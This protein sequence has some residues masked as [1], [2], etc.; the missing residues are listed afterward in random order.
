MVHPR[1]MELSWTAHP[2]KRRPR[3]LALVCAV[4][5]LTAG[6]VL[7]SFESL[8]LTGLSALIICVSTASFLFPTHY[9][10]S[11]RGM[12]ER[13]LWTRRARSWADLRRLQVGK[14]AALISPFARKN[15]LDRYRGFLV[16]FDGSDR[17]Q[18]VSELRRRM[19]MDSPDAA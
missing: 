13:R 12:E 11:D 2:A 17:E 9:R 19:G 15:R 3:D 6:A 10:I 7:M 4:A 8:F 1:A 14:D 5:L 16:L 18:V